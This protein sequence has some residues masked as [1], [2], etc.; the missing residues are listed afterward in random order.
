MA[1]FIWNAA[2]NFIGFAKTDADKNY[3]IKHE[4]TAK[5]TT[6][7]DADFNS[8]IRGEKTLHDGRDVNDPAAE[9]DPSLVANYNN[10]TLIDFGGSVANIENLKGT[11]ENCLSRIN[12]HLNFHKGDV[13]TPFNDKYN[14]HKTNLN[15]VL[16][17]CNAGSLTDNPSFPIDSLYKYM[18]SRFG[19]AVHYQEIPS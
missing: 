19:S 2:D 3:W 6:P 13:D 15:T 11:V 7:S 18:E 5:T 1:Y 4:P 8:F 16:A 17:E 9:A 14:A 10:P 12:E